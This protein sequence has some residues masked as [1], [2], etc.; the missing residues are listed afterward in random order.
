MAEIK[1]MKNNLNIIGGN[2]SDERRSLDFYPTPVECTL[3]L[4]PY[5]PETV[6]TVW[7]PACGDG[8]ISK[9]L[10]N[11]GFDVYSTELRIDSGYGAGGLDFLTHRDI[12]TDAIITNPPFN[13]SEDFINKA[14]LCSP[15]VAML[16]KSQYWHAKT[17]YKLFTDHT[18]TYILP[19]TWRP[20]FFGTQ[21]RG[22]SMLDMQWTVWIQGNNDA[23]Y[24]PL[25][26][27][28][29]NQITLQWPT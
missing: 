9:V 29:K 26:K 8:A 16:L 27:P 20:N 23:K 21:A 5:I 28:F 10:V 1:N 11:N 2:P 13:V 15:V 3:A 7:E 6:N 25:K 14:L 12:S 24:I 17:R 4:L 18:P 19:L 22:S